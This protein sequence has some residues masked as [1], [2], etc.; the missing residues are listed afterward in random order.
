MRRWCRHPDYIID[1]A[2]RP[3]RRFFDSFHAPILYYSFEDDTYAPQQSVEWLAARYRN[4]PR[5]G[6]HVRLSD[7]GARS[8]GHFG[9]FRQSFK[10]QLWSE[11]AQWLERQ[12]LQ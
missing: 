7:V 4:S 6:R 2:G 1:D 3:I 9:F 11:T 5:E 8:I 10:D 12:R